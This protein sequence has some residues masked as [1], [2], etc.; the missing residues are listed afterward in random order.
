MAAHIEVEGE[1]PVLVGALQNGAVMHEPGAVEY[2]VR[3]TDFGREL[4]YLRV[5]ENV[6]L[7]YF[8]ARRAFQLGEFCLVQIGC[9]HL[10]T[11]ARESQRG[12]AT[13]TLSCGSDEGNLT[14]QSSSH[15]LPLNIS[16][17]SV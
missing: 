6:E 8:N 16:V 11:L 1:I 9:P 15:A 13:D 7:A 2:D 5:L 17:V 4:R 3:R 12:G 10:G 14:A